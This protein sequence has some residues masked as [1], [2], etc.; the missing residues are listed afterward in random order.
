MRTGLGSGVRGKIPVPG[1]RVVESERQESGIAGLERNN[2]AKIERFEDI[3]A[4]GEAQEVVNNIYNVTSRGSFAQDFS[5]TH[6]LHLMRPPVIST[7]VQ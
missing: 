4:W 7:S 1:G 5:L 3:R 2:M 6:F